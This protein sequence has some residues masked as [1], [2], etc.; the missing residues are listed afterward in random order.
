M[1]QPSPLSL[2]RGICLM[3]ALLAVMTFAGVATAAGPGSVLVL[4]RGDNGQEITNTVATLEGFGVDVERV[5]ALPEDISGYDAVWHVGAYSAITEDEV[6]GLASYV[7]A[8]GSAYLTGERPCCEP[9]NNSV[10]QLLRQ[11]LVNQ[12]VTV[13]GRGDTDGPFA[14]NTGVTDFVASFPNLLVD[15]LP[16]SPG[17]IEGIGNVSSR[18]VFAS[19]GAVAVGAVWSEQD[20]ASGAGRVVLLMD[21]D[22]LQ[23]TARDRIIENIHNF[24]MKGV[25][26]QDNEIAGLRWTAGPGP[27]AVLLSPTTLTWSAQSD[28]GPVEINV[29]GNGISCPSASGTRDATLTC[30]LTT[31]TAEGVAFRVEVTGPEGKLVRRYRVRPKNDP[32]NVPV[33]FSLDSNWWTWPDQDQDGIP[34]QWERDGVWVKGVYLDLPAEGSD[35]RRK[36]LY[37]HYD[38]QEGQELPERTFSFM[39]APFRDA[40]LTNPDGTTG[41]TLHIQRGDSIPDSVVGS[42]ALDVSSI[43]R[44]AGYSGFLASPWAGGGGVPQLSKWLFNRNPD[45]SATIGQAVVGGNWGYTAWDPSRLGA[46]VNGWQPT[47][48]SLD[49]SRGVNAVHELGHQLGLLHHGAESTPTHDDDYRSVMSYSYS[50]FGLPSGFLGRDHHIDYSREDRVNLDWRVGPGYGSLTFVAGQW[51]ERPDFYTANNAETLDVSGELSVEPT[52]IEAIQ[53]TNPVALRSFQEQFGLNPIAGAPEVQGATAQV[54]V[55]GTVRIPVPVSAPSGDAPALV[56]D[57]GPSLGQARVEGAAIVYT[58]SAVGTDSLVVRAV[59]GPLG[60]SQATVTVTVTPQVGGPPAGGNPSPGSGSGGTVDRPAVKA[61]TL[62]L[63]GVTR[64]QGRTN[65]RVRV[66]V[67]RVRS[68]S[69][70]RLTL[71]VAHRSKACAKRRSC[72]GST[73]LRKNLRLKAGVNRIV[74]TLPPRAL[75]RSPLTLTLTPR[76]AQGATTGKALVRRIGVTRTR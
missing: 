27:C 51:G 19:N 53:S 13:G 65:G 24:L 69:A 38:F 44:T 16:D 71:R 29:V 1:I 64:L 20:M 48:E 46:L 57:R 17:G 63:L 22:Y 11:V 72:V 15:F 2:R 6:A 34:D 42:F 61:P 66:A 37:L 36:D 45:G 12:D 41:V 43:Q 49:F 54:A 60:S 47:Q 73:L 67:I 56:I 30:A 39:S 21:I 14:F 28:Q 35:P 31:T 10:Q 50:S 40:P 32:R 5:S 52:L 59:A 9:L 33:P 18:N 8:G 3:L 25:T 76:S 23:Q 26:C 4:G 62:R 70:G 68:S 75:R 7:A 58:A 55:G 74:I